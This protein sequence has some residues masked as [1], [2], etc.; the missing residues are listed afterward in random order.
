[1][2]LTWILVLAA[3]LVISP[4][5]WLLPSGRQRMQMELRRHAMSLGVKVR[6][7]KLNLQGQEIPFIAYRWMRTD[8]RE[9]RMM[10]V[11]WVRPQAFEDLCWDA[12]Q[13]GPQNQQDFY[14][15]RGREQDIPAAWFPQIQTCL[16]QLPVQIDAVELGS[17]ALTLWWRERG[18]LALLEALD[19]QVRKIGIAFDDR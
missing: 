5:F 9:A 6:L 14:L 16:Q 10:P 8:V 2:E 12:D 7:E 3:T 19:Q 4:I 17:A 13:E 15:I 11:L 1:M 18:D